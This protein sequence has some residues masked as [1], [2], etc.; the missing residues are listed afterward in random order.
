[1]TETNV[2][3]AVAIDKGIASKIAHKLLHTEMLLI[4][5]EKCDMCTHSNSPIGKR[6][7][8]KPAT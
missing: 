7:T 3:K 5:M 4:G 2:V 1:V 8:S 6:I